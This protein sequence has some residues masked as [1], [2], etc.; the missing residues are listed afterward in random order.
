MELGNVAEIWLHFSILTF[1]PIFY[2][3]FS[4]HHFVSSFQFKASGLVTE[5]F[6]SVTESLLRTL[7]SILVPV[8]YLLSS[9]FTSQQLQTA[10]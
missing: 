3:P 9:V 1:I 2:T 8:A 7:N 6:T 4:N 5:F 10:E